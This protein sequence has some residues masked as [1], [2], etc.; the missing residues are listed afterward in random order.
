MTKRSRLEV[1]ILSSGFL[2]AKPFENQQKSL[3]F[4]WFNKMAASRLAFT[5]QNRTRCSKND[6]LNTGRSGIWWFTIQ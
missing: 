5:I 4:E 3:V 1:K 6:H 2:M